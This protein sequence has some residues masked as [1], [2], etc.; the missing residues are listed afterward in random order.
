LMEPSSLIPKRGRRRGQKKLEKD[1]NE[2]G[3]NDSESLTIQNNSDYRTTGVR[4]TSTGYNLGSVK[5]I[6]NN[7]SP[8]KWPQANAVTGR[9]GRMD[10]PS[11]GR[12]SMFESY[13]T[14]N[15]SKSPEST[16][17]VDSY[18]L[19]IDER[20]VDLDNEIDFFNERKSPINHEWSP[21]STARLTPNKSRLP[22]KET[23][24]IGIQ[25]EI[26]IPVPK[27]DTFDACT[28]CCNIEIKQTRPTKMLS[29]DLFER[30]PKKR[31][32]ESV[33]QATVAPVKRYDSSYDESEMAE[34]T[35]KELEREHSQS[36]DQRLRSIK[37]WMDNETHF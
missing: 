4:C 20:S 9:L 26:P 11:R 14:G 29:I 28:Q 18:A 36:L 13:N 1:K 6:S 31:K 24:E 27:P 19:Q 35:N 23:A 21:K 3:W 22:V 15:R 10:G 7:D 33:P 16:I 34:P 2:S 12:R 30:K 25:C 32:I 17:S 8:Y 37:K 5:K